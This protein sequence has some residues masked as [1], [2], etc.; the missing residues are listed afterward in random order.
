MVL[1]IVGVYGKQPGLQAPV[2]TCNTVFGSKAQRG[3][4]QSKPPTSALTL[5]KGVGHTRVERQ[6]GELP[7]ERVQPALGHPGG[8]LGG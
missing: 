7:G 1:Q 2:G 3:V 4:M 6:R 8:N 5:A